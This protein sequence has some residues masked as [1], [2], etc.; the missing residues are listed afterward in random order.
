MLTDDACY[1]MGSPRTTKRMNH[2]QKQLRSLLI[3]H[4]PGIRLSSAFR[5]ADRPNLSTVSHSQIT[6]A[7][8]PSR[9]AGH[10][11]QSSVRHMPRTFAV[12]LPRA[13]TTRTCPL[14]AYCVDAVRP[15][16]SHP[17]SPVTRRRFG[18]CFF[19]CPSCPQLKQTLACIALEA[20]HDTVVATRGGEL[21]RSAASSDRGS[22]LGA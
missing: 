13:P 18:H 7:R 4:C 10:P 21:I 6:S 12:S 11:H 9:G 15:D 2:P 17:F 8:R 22:D 5:G 1:P 19:M 20:G 16:R 3:I 14:S